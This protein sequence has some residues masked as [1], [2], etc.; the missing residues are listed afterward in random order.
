MML[1]NKVLTAIMLLYSMHAFSGIPDVVCNAPNTFWVLDGQTAEVKEFEIIGTTIVYTGNFIPD[2]PGFSL[3]ISYNLNGGLISPTL[4]TSDF[5]NNTYYW[6]GGSNWVEVNSSSVLFPN[7]GGYNNDLYFQFTSGLPSKIAR[8]DGVDYVHI[9]NINKYA[10]VADIATD[11]SGNVW[12]ITTTT[13]TATDSVYQISPTG[14]VLQKYALVLNAIN[15]YGSFFLDDVLYIGFGGN[16]P[17]YP[18]SLIPVT[19]SATNAVAGA[20]IA[21]PPGEVSSTYDLASCYPGPMI[22]LPIELVSF[23]AEPDKEKVKLTWTTAAEINCD[24]FLVQ[25]SQDAK[26]FY[27][28]AI[29]SGAGNSTSINNYTVFDDQPLNGI[30]YYRLKQYDFNGDFSYSK[31]VAVNRMSDDTNMFAFPNPAS[32][33]FNIYGLNFTAGD[34][35]VISDAL[36]RIVY[37]ELLTEDVLTVQV[38]T[39]SFSKGV[40]FLKV[41]QPNGVCSLKF[42]KE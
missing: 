11:G 2:C 36:G 35:I 17:F 42:I 38:A 41:K 16:N 18:N 19:F 5:S 30:S 14:Q 10:G 31:T 23:N 7:A 9:F 39:N 4:Y 13:F 12:L 3:A 29:T 22:I 8:F 26:A 15:A 6:N 40:Y 24:Y 34:E 28:I 27:E 37:K 21:L 20:P 33:E 1:I 32:S 25:R